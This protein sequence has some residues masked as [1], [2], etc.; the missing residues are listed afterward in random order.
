[1]IRD[2]WSTIFAEVQ[3]AATAV[4]HLAADSKANGRGI[5]VVPRQALEHGYVD[6]GR[7]ELDIE[8]EA[9]EKWHVHE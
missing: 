7:D 3:D 8:L 4:L 6:L 9:A 2:Q 5:G 1:M